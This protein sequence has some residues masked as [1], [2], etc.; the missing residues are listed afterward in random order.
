MEPGVHGTA[1]GPPGPDLVGGPQ[2]AIDASARPRRVAELE[3][4]PQDGVLDLDR[5]DRALVAGRHRDGPGIEPQVAVV[6]S[7]LAVGIDPDV[8]EFQVEIFQRGE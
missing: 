3:R 1:A 2:G 4:V 6:R 8:G 7:R 5:R